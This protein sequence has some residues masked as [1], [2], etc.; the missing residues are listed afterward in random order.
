MEIVQI[1]V[2]VELIQDVLMV[3]LKIAQM[4]TVH[5]LI[6]LV[7]VIAMEQHNNMV[8]IY[9]VMILMVVTVLLK[10]VL[11]LLVVM[12]PVMELKI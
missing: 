10:S 11:H 1:L 9:A 5:L 6:G 8:L 2:V 3:L 12:V 7:M 4:M